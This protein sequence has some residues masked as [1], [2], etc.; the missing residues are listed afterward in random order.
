MKERKRNLKYTPPLNKTKNNITEYLVE[1]I[2]YNNPYL[3]PDA[4]T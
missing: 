3:N 2:Y 1:Y 4:S